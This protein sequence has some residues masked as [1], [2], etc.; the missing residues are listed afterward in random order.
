MV[1]AAVRAGM[2]L[3]AVIVVQIIGRM[4]LSILANSMGRQ[5]VV[6]EVPQRRAT[7]PAA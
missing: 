1:D 2:N 4:G 3:G 5:P 6:T 7:D